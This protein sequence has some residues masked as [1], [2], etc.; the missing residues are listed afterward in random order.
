MG[1][2]KIPF[3]SSSY[4]SE[5]TSS[6][7]NSPFP[8]FTKTKL[9]AGRF[10]FLARIFFLTLSIIHCPLS[11]LKGQSKF[12]QGNIPV[13]NFTTKQYK[14]QAQNWTVTQDKFGVL[15]FGNH[16]NILSYDGEDWRTLYITDEP[17]ISSL[18]VYE[19]V[20]YVGGFNDFGVLENK[21]SKYVF[22][23]LKTESFNEEIHSIIQVPNKI[24]F[25]S[26]LLSFIYDL[27]TK[28]IEKVQNTYAYTKVYKINNFI[29]AVTENPLD[30]LILVD[31][32]MQKIQS[33]E[34]PFGINTK[35]EIIP[36]NNSKSLIRTNKHAL[37]Y[38]DIEKLKIEKSNLI[39]SE[40]IFQDIIFDASL[41][42]QNN[43]SIGTQNLGCLLL[44]PSF[45]IRNF[46]NLSSGLNDNWILAQY[47]DQQKN[48]WLALNNGI[49]KLKVNTPIT[50]FNKQHHL[51]GTVEAIT[52]CY[53][54][55]FIATH[56]GFYM[57]DVK[58]T[59][60]VKSINDL[61]PTFI[62]IKGDNVDAQCWDLLNF[63]SNHQE[64]LLGISNIGLHEIYENGTSTLIKPL[65]AYCL[66]QSKSDPNRLF[67]GVENGLISFYKKGNIWVDEGY[68]CNT[69]VPVF[70]II[71]QNNELW[72][73][74]YNNGIAYRLH[75]NIEN[76]KIKISQSISF[77]PKQNL[78]DG[79]VLVNQFKNELFFPTNKGLHK[80]DRVKNSFYRESFYNNK[81]NDTASY[82]HRMSVDPAGN[83]WLVTFD[84]LK[85]QIEIGFFNTTYDG[86]TQWNSAAFNELEDGDI[87]A[88]YH[89]EN[90]ITWLGGQYGLFRFDAKEMK[91]FHPNY[92]TQIRK[93]TLNND[94]VIFWG[95]F[96]DAQGKPTLIQ[97]KNEQPVIDYA[98]RKISFTFAGQDYEDNENKFYRYR[99]NNENWSPWD[100]A[101]K[102]TFEELH[103]GTYT[104]QV[105]TKNRYG[106]L[107]ESSPFTFT[108]LPPWYRHPAMLVTWF[109]LLIIF[110]ISLIYF[111]TKNLRSIIKE[112]TAE[113]VKQKEI[114]EAKNNDI[115]SSIDYA[116]KIQQALLPSQD[117]LQK[118]FTDSF[119]LFLPRDIVSGDFYWVGEKNE[120]RF[121]AVMDCTGH[122]V[123]GAFMSMI[124]HSLL[125]E[126]IVEK[127]IYDPA[128]VL[129]RM[130]KSITQ[131]LNQNKEATTRDGMD[132]SICAY[133]PEQ[134]RLLFAGANNHGYLIRTK[135]D[136]NASQGKV[137]RENAEKIIL[138]ITAD[139]MPVGF[140]D[141]KQEPFKTV[142]I[143]LEQ[144]DLVYLFSDGYVDQ[145]GGER[146]KKFKKAN[147]LILLLEI[148]SLP[149]ESQKKRLL[150]VYETW[151]GAE[152]Q[153]DDICVMGVKI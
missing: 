76:K 9:L 119:I 151:K 131:A 30:K 121:F 144:G 75:F 34:I 89:D 33:I 69:Q 22:K 51:E 23:S 39:I 122:G 98:Y 81:L 102:T 96:S 49:A 12:E 6:R 86:K 10:F 32:R 120:W 147:L 56:H 66:Y 84:N 15:Y 125:N 2:K 36:W 11:I 59:D 74:G 107:S 138:E 137:I 112:R 83:V 14:G 60:K 132:A 153:V 133:H 16:K 128:E 28:N 37:F 25:Q 140:F 110:V 100:R 79:Q 136:K 46:S 129:N 92:Y 62:P 70:R 127:E 130:R 20:I 48:L 126:L 13:T 115:V 21:N 54:N 4:F 93:V 116:Q 53:G 99:L 50:Y 134:N 73:G 31:Q 109:L 108:I 101:N 29:F 145:F 41:S 82:I 24:I 42:F 87:H 18:L 8:I 78:P 55:L 40:N 5:R 124:G 123:P 63:K 17:K 91:A 148:Y 26:K 149:L 118:L 141:A 142:E 7:R 67:V 35:F 117:L 139:K 43:I 61:N 1:L 88:I 57:M 19:D 146:G 97:P 111:Y 150:N 58:T 77:G 38:L 65:A 3:Q 27:K 135:N 71:E 64:L 52:R 103:E 80:F 95:Q 90:G 105:Q 68:L 143:E 114:I 113:V 47:I 152:Q 104:F 44:D 106:V 94:S 72:L 45:K 85:N